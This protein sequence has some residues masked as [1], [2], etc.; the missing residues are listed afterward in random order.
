MSQKSSKY[1]ANKSKSKA[2]SAPSITL[3]LQGVSKSYMSQVWERLKQGE[4]PQGE[5]YILARSMADHRH[6][7]ALFET[8]GIFDSDPSHYVGDVDPYL[9]IQL[10]HMIGLQILHKTPIQALNFYQARIQKQ[11]DPHEIIHMMIEIF[12][13]HMMKMVEQLVTDEQMQSL[14][15]QLHEVDTSTEDKAIHVQLNQQHYALQLKKLQIKT[16]Q[17]IWHN[18]G[19]NEIPH[20]HTEQELIV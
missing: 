19:F 3:E 10:H 2:K 6:W 18:L 15:E 12:K 5:E 14:H 8:I 11:E 7:Y 9:H 17:H 16:R 20:L 4:V 1:Q 13:Q